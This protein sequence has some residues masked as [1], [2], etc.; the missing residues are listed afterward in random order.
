MLHL[1]RWGN[2]R[3][4]YNLVKYFANKV[5][6]FKK[7]LRIETIAIFFLRVIYSSLLSPPLRSN[8]KFHERVPRRLASNSICGI[9]YLE[10]PWK[11]ERRGRRGPRDFT[12]SRNLYRAFR[13]DG[14][15]AGRNDSRSL[16]ILMRN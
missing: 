5:S 8:Y 15:S 12:K 6:S 3:P 1:S 10:V 4:T 13:R 14:L 11:S 2:F 9:S 7:P 16:A